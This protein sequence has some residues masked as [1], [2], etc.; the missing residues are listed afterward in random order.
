VAG[1]EFTGAQ[2]GRP[3]DHPTLYQQHRSKPVMH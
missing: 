1:S 2:L 3:P